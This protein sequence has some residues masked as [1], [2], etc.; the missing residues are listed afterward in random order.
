MASASTTKLKTVLTSRLRL[1][2]PEFHLERLSG[3]KLSGNIVSDTFRGVDDV[4]RQRRIWDALDEEFGDGSRQVVGTLLA[5]TKSEWN[6]PL[7][8]DPPTMQR[9]R[10]TK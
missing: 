6:V 4:E 8:G 3:G 1:R 2:D 7:E 9:Q 5:Y 10:K